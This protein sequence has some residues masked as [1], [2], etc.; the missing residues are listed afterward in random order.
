MNGGRNADL[1]NRA[2]DLRNHLLLTRAFWLDPIRN[3]S[4]FSSVKRTVK[5]LLRWDYSIGMLE[6]SAVCVC[7][8]CLSQTRSD[9]RVFYDIQHDTMF[10]ARW[11]ACAA[12]YYLG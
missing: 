3:Y 11:K 5:E 1:F 2:R 12:M 9:V 8:A 7:L 4:D 6:Y 10:G